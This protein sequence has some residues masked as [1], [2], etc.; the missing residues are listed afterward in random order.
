V[1]WKNPSGVLLMQI[2]AVMMVI[3]VVWMVRIVNFRI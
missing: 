1:L 3:G 2:T